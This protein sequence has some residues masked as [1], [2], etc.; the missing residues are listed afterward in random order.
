MCG[1][2]YD[3]QPG[4]CPDSPRRKRYVLA[5]DDYKAR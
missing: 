1:I 3:D 4:T 2:G 5:G